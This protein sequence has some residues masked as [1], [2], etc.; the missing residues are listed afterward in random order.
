[1]PFI[2]VI[3]PV[4][5]VEK[6][7]GEMIESVQNQSLRDL[8]IILVDDGSPDGSGA[9]CDSYAEK[10]ARIKVIHKK[11]AGVGAARNDGLAIAKGDWV[12]FCDSD[13]WLE[14]NSMEKLVKVGV[15]TDADVVFGDVNLAYDDMI[16]KVQFYKNEFVLQ[17]REEIDRL[18]EADFSRKYCFDPPEAGPA[19]G[20]GGPWNKIVRRQLLSAHDIHFNLEVKGI[21]DDII[22]TAYI[23]GAAKKVAYVHVPVYNYRQLDSSITH[24][25]KQNLLD[26]NTAIFGAWEEFM[27]IYGENGKFQKP[28]YANVMRRFQ[29]TLGLYFFNEKNQKPFHTQLREL[30]ELM[31]SEPYSTA[32]RDVDPDKLHNNYY[33]LIWKASRKHSALHV[34]L[35]YRMMLVI[36]KFKEKR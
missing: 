32:I 36:K 7:I 27:S 17:Q 13:D 6:Y 8:E 9:I 16:K 34:Y 15:E 18:I 14:Q 23:F 26:I 19:F 3:V 29:S 5:N 25:Y 30:K 22:Y 12:I 28:Y 10:D 33:K 31:D 1:M 4:Y 20:Y 24:S 35:A 21:F 2:S 11:N